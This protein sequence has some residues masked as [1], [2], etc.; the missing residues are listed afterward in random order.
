[1]ELIPYMMVVGEKDAQ[2]GTVTVRDRLDGDLGAMP[3]EAALAKLREEVDAKT[4]R[5]V[6]DSK[7]APLVDHRTKNEY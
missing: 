2:N 6:A 4:V 5:Q 3:T 1:L 7:A